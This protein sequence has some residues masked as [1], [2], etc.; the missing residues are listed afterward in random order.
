MIIAW[1]FD[2][3]ARAVRLIAVPVLALAVLGG[4]AGASDKKAAQ[5]P[6]PKVE[7]AKSDVSKWQTVTMEELTVT[8]PASAKS[9]G[10]NALM[11]HYWASAE[12][13]AAYLAMTI[14][15]PDNNMPE[16]K[17]LEAMHTLVI[18]SL[19][20]ADI[21]SKNPD[22]K[23]SQSIKED[24]DVTLGGRKGKEWLELVQQ[25]PITTRMYLSK[26]HVYA[27]VVIN[28]AADDAVKEKLFSS[29]AFAGSSEGSK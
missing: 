15:K 1:N 17:L 11:R 28:T 14:E 7:S 16:D 4:A 20:D 22:G 13:K 2:A 8:M 23:F 12:G 26:G 9:L 6:A 10:T 3:A 21:I 29:M 25:V 19:V 27:A 24:K 5:K 18:Q